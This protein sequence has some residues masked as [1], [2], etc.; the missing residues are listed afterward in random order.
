[1]KKSITRLIAVLIGANAVNNS[2]AQGTFH[3]AYNNFKQ[4]AEADYEDFRSKANKEYADWM[5]EAWEWHQKIEPMPRPK[6]EMMPPVI[7]E[8]GK[9]EE[10]E[11]EQ[12]KPLPHEEVIPV[13]KPAPQPNPIA[14]IRENEEEYQTASFMFFGTN[15]QVRLP[16][17]YTFRLK[18]NDEEAFASAW[19]ELSSNR[20]D[21]LILDCLK[22]RKEH[23]LC[24]WAYL[25]MLGALSE[26]VCGKGTNEATMMQAFL[27]CQSGYKIRMG[28]TKKKDLRLLFKSDHLIFDLN[29][30][31]MDDGNYYLLLPIDDEGLNV[32]DISYPEEKP[33]SLWITKEQKFT[34]K[35][36]GE[37]QLTSKDGMISIKTQTNKNLLAF[38]STYPTSMLGK[39]VVS[40]WAM[41]AKTPLS[42]STRKKIY[43]Q[44]EAI[45]RNDNKVLAANRLLSWVQTAFV[46]EYDDKV[47]GRDRAFFAEE[48]LF[49]PY[50]DCE[51]RSILF[52]RLVR[53]LLGLEVILVF[54]PGHLATAVAFNTPVEGDYIELNSKRYTIC[55]PT[56]IGAPIGMTMDGMDNKTAKVIIL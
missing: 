4:K 52:S 35:I 17:D 41:Y 22:L 32:C 38:Y 54:Y 1:M 26:S 8:K 19:E 10:K 9:E 40:R 13:P 7:Y 14:P 25:M 55:D 2:Y 51:D 50:C 12:S 33:L 47:W 45:V 36:S 42:S 11:K 44:L 43:P 37:R 30:I 28:F 48:T 5:R 24:D 18:G 20:Y 6:D 56:Y 21:N 49:Y 27:L 15:G 31:K 23:Q 39:D 53:D 16:K 29:G 3:D 46:Y 34:E